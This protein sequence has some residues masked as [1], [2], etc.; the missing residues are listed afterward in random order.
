M[1]LLIN[2]VHHHLHPAEWEWGTKLRFKAIHSCHHRKPAASQLSRWHRLQ[3]AGAFLLSSK[4][5]FFFFIGILRKTRPSSG[6]TSCY[7]DNLKFATVISQRIPSINA[8]PFIAPYI[9]CHNYYY[10]YPCFL[11]CKTW[12]KSSIY[13]VKEKKSTT[14]RNHRIP[15]SKVKYS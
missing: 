2:S 8:K 3:H 11:Y 12:Y 9:R 6:D 1:T 4:H 10:Y 13:K 14:N 15:K 5:P 7:L